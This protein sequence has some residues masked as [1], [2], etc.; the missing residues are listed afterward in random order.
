MSVFTLANNGYTTVFLP[1][2]Q[3]VDVFR[4]ND[5]VIS[6]TAPPALQGWQ[7]GRGLWMVPIVDD[8]TISPSIDVAET[9]MSVYELPSTKEVVR[10]LH[11][12][13]GHP[14]RATLL[15]SA[16]HGN[17]VTFPGMTPENISRHFPESDETQKGHMK[18][19]KQGVRSTKVVDEDAMLGNQPKP[20]VKHKD[21]YLKVFDATKKSMFS[22]QTGKFPITS[23]RRNKYIMVAVELD[24]NNIDGE[25]IQS[26]KAKSL[27]EAYQAIFQ[28]WK[29][30]GVICPN[31]HILDNEAPEEL[32]QAIRENNCRVELTPADQHRWNAAERAIQ[33]FKGHFISVLAGVVDGF[34]IN[35]WDELLPQTILTLNL[36]R[37]LNVASNISAYA[38]H[39]GSFDYNCMPITPMG[40]AVQFHIKPSRQKTFGEHSEDGF[41]L[42]MSAEHYRT[43]IV[44]CKKTRAKQLA[45]M[46]FFKH[47]HITQPTVTPVDAIVNAF[48]KL[49]E[50]IHGIQHSKYDA[51]FKALKRIESTLQ[52]SG[53][54]AIKTANKSNFQG[55][56]NKCKLHLPSMFQG[57]V[58]MMHHPRYMTLRLDWL[59][60]H[61]GSKLLS[62]NPN[63]SSNCPSIL[64]SP[65]QHGYEHDISNH[66]QPSTNQLLIK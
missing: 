64:T 47:K 63:P 7:D 15:T 4:T 45:D 9:A 36:L 17:I 32:K 52:P 23:A 26:R 8:P 34:P 3:G 16:Q 19:T 50:A 54:H 18:Q 33:T 28:R 59:S 48:N 43:H 44:F 12:A 46:V 66:K 30:T 40:C 35:Q 24:G 13:L 61:P 2:Q 1:G 6:S 10:F 20:G 51:H 65:L 14:P 25:P 41:Y 39:H 29:A 53:N 58:P 22:N 31:W 62:H 5:V 56:N 11:A 55:W 21:V 27:T 42:K 49:R 38:Y 57:C 37:Q 60:R